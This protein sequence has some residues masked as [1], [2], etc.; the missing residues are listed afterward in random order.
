MRAV[1]AAVLVLAGCAASPSAP[2]ASVV[3]EVS[4]ARAVAAWNAPLALSMRAINVGPVPLT[5]PCGFVV[6]VTDLEDH[7]VKHPDCDT[8]I[9]LP[10]GGDTRRSW[11]LNGETGPTRSGEY[12]VHAR[13]EAGEVAERGEFRV[14]WTGRMAAGPVVGGAAL[15]RAFAEGN[16]T[17]V[18]VWLENREASGVVVETGCPDVAF[19]AADGARLRTADDAGC[20]P[21]PLALDDGVVWSNAT[22]NGSASDDGGWRPAPPGTYRW[23]ST[24]H[25]TQQGEAK[26][27]GVEGRV[28]W[29]G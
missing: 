13:F 10:P 14:R 3:V 12:L 15:P 4:A 9:T 7:L 20:T 21:T 25:Y 11:Q 29:R 5:S 23:V 19:F 2:E 28:E 8:P 1:L 18:R 16:V 6:V 17:H 26:R 24:W 22:W 27:Q